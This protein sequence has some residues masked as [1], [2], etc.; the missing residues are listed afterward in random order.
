MNIRDSTRRRTTLINL[1]AET[2]AGIKKATAVPRLT[3][4]EDDKRDVT[5]GHLALTSENGI[6]PA[7]LPE[8]GK[9]D[10]KLTTVAATSNTE[11]VNHVASQTD[12]TADLE[13]TDGGRFTVQAFKDAEG[14]K[15]ISSV[16]AALV[17]VLALVFSESEK[18]NP[19]LN[20]NRKRNEGSI[21]KL[22][23]LDGS[24]VEK[25]SEG[26]LLCIVTTLQSSGATYLW[27]L[28]CPFEE[29]MDSPENAQVQLSPTTPSVK[30][31][32]ASPIKPCEWNS[33]P[34][35]KRTSPL[36]PSK[37]LVSRAPNDDKTI[38]KP[39]NW[40]V[41]PDIVKAI[42]LF[43]EENQRC[44]RR[45][46]QTRTAYY[47]TKLDTEIPQIQLVIAVYRQGLLT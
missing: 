6:L 40:L 2:K 34:S 20:L 14:A 36:F 9:Q 22:T 21:L 43:G 5:K 41:A 15:S 38:S 12:L 7:A 8:C 18:K 32:G 35:C 46:Q 24:I 25:R 30:M 19:F 27:I 3:F 33:S 1:F 28:K 47:L 11:F 10:F 39:R 4:V 45:N 16:V 23:P 26:N 42:P 37:L 31:S 29:G 17:L 13:I 44:A